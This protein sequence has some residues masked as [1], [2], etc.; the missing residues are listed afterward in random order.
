MK[1]LTFILATLL[2][3]FALNISAQEYNFS[4]NEKNIQ[5]KYNYNLENIGSENNLSVNLV[6]IEEGTEYNYGTLNLNSK[7]L[8]NANELSG[9]LSKN[10]LSNLK[11]K[12]HET[13]LRHSASIDKMAMSLKNEKTFEEQH[14]YNYQGYFIFKSIFDG[15]KRDKKKNG[16]I[17]FTPYDGF[18]KA[19]SS[20]VCEE[21]I[22][23][24]VNDMNNFLLVKKKSDPENVGVDYYLNALK[25]YYANE[26]TFKEVNQRLSNSFS[27]SK[28]P[29]GGACGCCGNYSGPCVFWSSVCLAHDMACQ[30]CQHSW[31]FSGCVASSCSGNTMAW[32]FFI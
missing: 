18:I 17:T 7:N 28:W 10:Y 9:I 14:A 23:F 11:S 16:Q 30:Q 4:D 20:F 6:V 32:Y 26:I 25:G 31:C 29:S 2:F 8:T 1:K 15:A 12:K 24:N 19:I 13:V 3:S 5:I 27:S 22:V 21:D